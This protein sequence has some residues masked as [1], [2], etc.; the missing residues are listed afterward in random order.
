MDICIYTSKGGKH[1][2]YYLNQSINESPYELKKDIARFPAHEIETLISSAL[3]THLFDKAKLE[4]LLQ[5]D[6]G[7][8]F[9][10][11][12]QVVGNFIVTGS[13]GVIAE[14]VSKVTVDVGK[15]QIQ[16]S[17]YDLNKWISWEFKV[18]FPLPPA[19]LKIHL[20]VPFKR[21]R[22]NKGAWILNPVNPKTNF[23]DLPPH[24]LTSLIRGTI[25][26]DEYFTG[27]PIAD[28]AQREGLDQSHILR[29]IRRSLEIA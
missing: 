4:K 15:L 14:A 21:K 3:E 7:E 10:L 11:V 17:P 1:Y 23:L 19:D 24:E 26:R 22:A 13:A 9:Q 2:R 20:E 29:L 27:T 8:H 25:W 18:D 5:L 12:Q 28:I 16:I 6:E